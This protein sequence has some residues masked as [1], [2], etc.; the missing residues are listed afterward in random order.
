LFTS[1]SL[2]A[3]VYALMLWHGLP[4]G[5][6]VGA[7]TTALGVAGI[8]ASGCIYRVPSRPAWNTPYTPLQFNVTAGLLGPLLAGAIGAGDR[9]ALAVAAATMAGVQ[10]AL[11]ALGFF[12]LI[13]SDVM[14]LRSTVRLLSTV[15]AHRLLLRG[16][17]LALGGVVLPLAGAGAAVAGL[18]LV[19]AVGAEI[20]GRYLFFVSVVPKHL[21]APY[22]APASEAV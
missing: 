9:R 15:L 22:I 1:F 5:P 4:G 17:L 13:A 18:A 2:V 10:F 14:E 19:L 11:L 3:G 8:T 20:L 21:A 6:W 7:L 16:V 12:R